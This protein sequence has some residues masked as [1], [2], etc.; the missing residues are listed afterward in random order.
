MLCVNVASLMLSWTTKS[1]STNVVS[2][3]KEYYYETTQTYDIFK[4]QSSSSSC[5]PSQLQ[6]GCSRSE[7]HSVP[8]SLSQLIKHNDIRRQ[9]RSSGSSEG[10]QKA[11]AVTEK[12]ENH[13]FR[14]LFTAP[15]VTFKTR[16]M[17]HP[18]PDGVSYRM[19]SFSITPH[20]AGALRNNTPLLMSSRRSLFSLSKHNVLWLCGKKQGTT[21]GRN[22]CF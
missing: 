13:L 3:F 15:E 20:S 21:S 11:A 5:F 9:R 2:L 14:G 19:I 7:E 18:T 10:V 16:A 1:R 4:P 12:E 8:S 17:W 22:M 6:H